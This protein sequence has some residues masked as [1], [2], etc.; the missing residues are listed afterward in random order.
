MV[1]AAA[2]TVA[3][4]PLGQV[5]R[6]QDL[7]S[8]VTLNKQ[9]D[10]AI[11]RG[12]A[13]LWSKHH[14]NQWDENLP[15]IFPRD[16][17]MV[18]A[19][20]AYA[21]LSSGQSHQSPRMTATLEYL[22]HA[23][24]DSVYSRSFR[25]LAISLL[26]S[27]AYR[28][29]LADDVKYLVSAM[30]E[31]GSFGYDPNAPP[32]EWNNSATQIAMMALAAAQ[33]AGQDVPE[34]FWRRAQQH[35]QTCQTAEGG[36][37]YSSAQ[38]PAYGSMTAAGV[39]SLYL[40]Q[41]I[42]GR[43]APPGLRAYE[44]SPQIKR[45]LL[46]LGEHFSAYENPGRGPQYYHQWL[47]CIEKAAHASGRRYFGAHNWFNEAATQL[48][49]RQDEEGKWDDEMGTAFSLLFFA[50]ARQSVLFSKLSYEGSGDIRPNDLA[51]LVDWLG[52]T[53]ETSVRWQVLD[54][55]APEEDW[56][57]APILYI[58]GLA[59]PSL[60]PQEMDKLRRFC[61]RGGLIW[62]ETAGNNAAFDRQMRDWYAKL[63]P[64]WPLKSI[65]PTDPIYTAHAPLSRPI[66]MLGISNGVRLLA[67]HVPVDLSMAYQSYDTAEGGDAFG[68]AAN[69]YFHVGDVGAL[70]R[71]G[72]PFVE[73]LA[74]APP[75][76]ARASKL[77]RAAA[78]AATKPAPKSIRVALLLSGSDA[79][80]LAYD[81]LAAAMARQCKVDLQIVRTPIEALDAHAAPIA[82]LSGTQ[83]F[84]FDAEQRQALRSFMNAGGLVVADALGG[85]A[86]FDIAARQQLLT[87]V[88]EAFP[89]VA[90]LGMTSEVLQR[91]GLAIG[92]VSYRRAARAVYGQDNA[93]QLQAVSVAGRPVIIYSRDDLTAGLVGY[94]GHDFRGYS[95]ASALAIMRNLILYA[96]QRPAPARPLL[97]GSVE[98]QVG[99]PEKQEN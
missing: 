27:P 23:P 32:D 82:I 93:A 28:T 31:D 47:W 20:C 41:E 40:C 51:H 49:R 43:Q 56:Y 13:Y 17:G 69:L 89:Q 55:D 57:D 24:L 59:P 48:V 87:L 50:Q 21:L 53:T 36:W 78:T 5:A 96:A 95:P 77:S 8:V 71:R 38:A 42:L 97:R 25:A 92:S 72:M 1:F 81:R 80:P 68:L 90:R 73:P 61:L 70:R 3:V 9:S 76:P 10:V 60:T 85:A 45:G 84:A 33:S 2:L 58:S 83:G 46:W 34:W 39:A 30:R 91:P 64:Q 26:P 6:G 66:P 74:D 35:W 94:R 88:D 18:T 12:I 52:R 4:A 16:K 7:S 62:S 44:V 79:E 11:D 37:S 54:I 15:G 86:A 65:P 99:Q 67:V 22:A 63:L 14:E 75:A 98:V 29:V 19:L